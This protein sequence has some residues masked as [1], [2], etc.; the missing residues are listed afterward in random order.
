MERL[1]PGDMAVL[2]LDSPATPM[3]VATVE[4]FEPPE[5]GFDYSRLVALVGDRLAF[6]PRYRQR[7]MNVPGGLARPVWVDDDDFDLTYHVR[8][9]AVPRPGS[10]QQVQELVMLTVARE[11][12][13]AYIWQAHAT[14]A[15]TAGVAGDGVDAIRERRTVTG[16]SPEEDAAMQFALELLRTRKVSQPTFDRAGAAFGRRGTQT[17]TNLIACYATL[18]YNMNAYELEAPVRAGEPALPV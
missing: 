10:M 12:D 16:L 8:Q 17:L 15:R 11:M 9:S 18:A 4:V 13:C 3:H 1:R 7:L 2:A 6:V 5:E 14:A